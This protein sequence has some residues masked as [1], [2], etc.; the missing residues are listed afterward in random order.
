[1]EK[2]DTCRIDRVADWAAQG[3]MNCDATSKIQVNVVLMHKVGC[4]PCSSLFVILD[5]R[6]TYL[7]A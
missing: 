5:K 6:W 4:F 1:M 2:V 3:S 7:A